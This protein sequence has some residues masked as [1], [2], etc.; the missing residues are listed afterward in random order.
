MHA[1]L[2]STATINS[3]RLPKMDAPEMRAEGYG[4]R[5]YLSTVK[6]PNHYELNVVSESIFHTNVDICSYFDIMK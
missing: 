3:R 4:Y 6:N 5:P 2:V 1:K